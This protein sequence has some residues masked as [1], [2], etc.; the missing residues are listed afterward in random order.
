[1]FW[2][3]RN[4]SR[5]PVQ[6]PPDPEPSAP[7]PRGPLKA[8]DTVIRGELDEHYE[9]FGLTLSDV[10]ADLKQ[11]ADAIVSWGPTDIAIWEGS[12]LR[13]I[14][15]RIATGETQVTYR[16]D[17]HGEPPC[18]DTPADEADDQAEDLDE[19]A[20]RRTTKAPEPDDE[21]SPRRVATRAPREEVPRPLLRQTM[22]IVPPWDNGSDATLEVIVLADG[23]H[24][25]DVT[26]NRFDVPGL[27]EAGWIVNSM[28]GLEVFFRVVG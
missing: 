22:T 28:K 9:A 4:T 26:A 27:E 13:A 16:D 18:P 15:H 19:S 14:V 5:R 8:F 10:I 23:T 24:L 17:A 20:S 25:D 1:M 7:P 21:P 3:L 12:S 11:E 6:A 2:H